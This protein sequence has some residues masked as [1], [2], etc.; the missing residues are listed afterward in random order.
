MSSKELHKKPFI[1]FFKVLNL[2]F[3]QLKLKIFQNTFLKHHDVDLIIYS[4]SAN[5]V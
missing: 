3:L 5:P 4:F 2:S 1:N